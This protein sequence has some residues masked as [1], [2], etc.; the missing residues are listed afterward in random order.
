VQQIRRQFGWMAVIQAKPS[1]RAE[2]HA[3]MS[4]VTATILGTTSHSVTPIQNTAPVFEFRCLYTHDLRK[5]KKIWHDGSLRFHTFNRR[6][7][8]Y[9][10]TKNYIGD[11][12]WTDT[13]EFQE[14]EELRLD[15]GVLVQV[16][17]Q[18]GHTETDL[19]PIILDK[20]RPETAFSTPQ[21][22]VPSNKYSS[23]VRQARAVSQTRP[24]S[25]AAVLGASQGPMGRARLPTQSP[26]EH[27]QDCT[28]RRPRPCEGPPPKRSRTVKGEEN[29]AYNPS[30]VRHEQFQQPPTSKT[31]H[32]V[33]DFYGSRR[34]AAL[35]PG[36]SL[37]SSA[38]LFIPNS[39]IPPR[40][41]GGTRDISEEKATLE[42]QNTRLPSRLTPNLKKGSSQELARKCISPD[43]ASDHT[44]RHQAFSTRLTGQSREPMDTKIVA[45]DSAANTY[46]CKGTVTNKLRFA[47]EKPRKKLMYKDLLPYQQ[48]KKLSGSTRNEEA[49]KRRRRENERAPEESKSA[50][51]SF[52]RDSSIVSVSSD[53]EALSIA[54]QP[55][56]RRNSGATQMSTPSSSSGALQSP[57]PSFAN[58]SPYSASYT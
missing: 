9:D 29:V 19:A 15:K 39:R 25:L 44:C 17:E 2:S 13:S 38:D 45:G 34:R 21:M 36:K 30:R 18:I 33:G 42:T 49:Q 56:T 51:R 11:T 27:S 43:T 57:R 20:R 54:M 10:D 6:V 24:K 16:G 41:R 47:N 1:L 28:I 58:Q 26:F 50:E 14:G 52:S 23:G 32:F 4:T 22:S 37:E 31:V 5:K 46:S 35:Y 8:V 7:M 3:I 48:E 40:R 55:L 53:E 12:H